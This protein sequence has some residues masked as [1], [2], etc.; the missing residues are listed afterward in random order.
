MC[1]SVQCVYGCPI[2]QTFKFFLFK[3]LTKMNIFKFYFRLNT[4]K[5]QKIQLSL[6]QKNS[7]KGSIEKRNSSKIVEHIE[8]EFIFS[9]PKR[10]NCS[11]L[12]NSRHSVVW[13]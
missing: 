11:C 3:I 12:D 8:N 4:Y 7:L 10:V 5:Q 13:C 1:T 9:A 6:K 2:S